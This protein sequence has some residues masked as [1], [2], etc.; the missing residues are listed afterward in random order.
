[1]KVD[2]RLK[3]S[4]S[5]CLS[6][7]FAAVLTAC[8]SRTKAACRGSA[9]D[10]RRTTRPDR[11]AP[12]DRQRRAAGAHESPF[13]D[14]YEGRRQARRRGAVGH[15]HRRSIQEGR[16]QT[17][18]HRRHLFSEGA[19]RRHHP[20]AGAARLSAWRAKYQTLK[21]KDDV[22][23]WTNH[24]ASSAALQSS[25]LV[26]VATASSR[27]VQLDDYKGS[28]QGQD[29]RDCSSRSAGA[30]SLVLVRRKD[31]VC[32]AARR[33]RSAGAVR[34]GRVVRRMSPAE[35]R[36]RLLFGRAGRQDRGEKKLRQMEREPF[37]RAQLS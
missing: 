20:H 17:G 19:A 5:I 23:A 6:F 24:V 11:T 10:I 3:G 15:L 8:S 14:E 18:Q 28:T 25:D 21:W 32:A 22:V 27:R 7:L 33:C 35:P 4:R 13:V 9:G 30:R 37:R 1:M 34:S 31:F 16:P 2:A 26:F 12:A 29:A 36:R